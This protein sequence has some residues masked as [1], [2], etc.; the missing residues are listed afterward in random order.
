MDELAD[1]NLTKIATELKRTLESL[2][3]IDSGHYKTS[4]RFVVGG[5]I[6][7]S[8]P[9]PLGVTVVGV[10][11]TAYY[12]AHID[13][14]KSKIRP[15]VKALAWLRGHPEKPRF[16]A[17]LGPYLPISMATESVQSKGKQKAY[18]LPVLYVGQLNSLTGKGVRRRSRSRKSK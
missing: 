16:D 14:T 15:F 6:V 13:S 11:N 17:R 7:S 8:L 4:F 1:A 18:T 9:T 10:T 5:K 12:A 3:P 2:A